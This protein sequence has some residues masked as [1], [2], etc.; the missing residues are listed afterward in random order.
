MTYLLHLNQQ[1]MII[2]LNEIKLNT[3]CKP[4]LAD[5]TGN[6]NAFKGKDEKH[7]L[8]YCAA[9]MWRKSI[10][11]NGFDSEGQ[12]VFWVIKSGNWSSSPA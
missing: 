11:R 5:K 7:L 1:D 2:I 4:M 3:L 10:L 12:A 8:V 9:W 6:A